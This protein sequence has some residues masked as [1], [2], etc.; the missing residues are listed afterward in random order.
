MEYK[1][2]LQTSYI[3]LLN[4]F[5]KNRKI[6]ISQSPCFR[7][8][9]IGSCAAIFFIKLNDDGSIKFYEE[10]IDYLQKAITNQLTFIENPCI[11]FKVNS[12]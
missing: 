8:Q 4:N 7:I 12:K 3:Q 11:E 6:I 5:N 10:A 2:T 9:S 1:E